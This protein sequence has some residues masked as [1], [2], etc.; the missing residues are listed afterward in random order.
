[1]NHQMIQHFIH[2]FDDLLCSYRKG[3]NSQALLT[4]C[5]EDW[6]ATLDHRE[7]V[8]CI[9]MELSKAFDCLPHGLL[10]AKLHAY[11]FSSSVCEFIASYLCERRQRVKINNDHSEG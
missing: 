4:K 9:F 1:M 11:G 2:I 8:G 5:P 3:Y 7:I 6:K 10:V